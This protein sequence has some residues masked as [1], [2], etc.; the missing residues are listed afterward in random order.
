MHEARIEAYIKTKLAELEQQKDMQPILRRG[1]L[2]FG[3]DST[4]YGHLPAWNDLVKQKKKLKRWIWIDACCMAF[5]AIAFA[6]DYFDKFGQNWLKALVSLIVTSGFIMLVFI[7]S[8]Y[9]TLFL[10][11]R[12][13]EREIRKLIY[14]DILFQLK[15]DVGEGA[16]ISKALV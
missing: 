14:Q 6:G 15:K 12:Q 2:S 16:N 1:E 4:T 7:F 9:Y 8:S 13:A 10:K 11:F 5:T 3:I